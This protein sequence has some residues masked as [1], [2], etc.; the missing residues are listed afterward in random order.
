MAYPPVGQAGAGYPGGAAP[1]ASPSRTKWVLGVVIGVLAGALVAGTLG[2][3]I[4]A[5]GA[6]EKPNDPTS[7]PGP[8]TSLR[9]YEARQLALNKEKFSGDLAVLAEP[10]L[11][12]VGACAAN[13][14]PNGPKLPADEKVHVFCRYGNVS[15]HFAEYNSAANRDNARAYRHRLNLDG[16]DLVPGMGQP[17]RK[18]GGSTNAQG[19]YVEY[20]FRGSDGRALCGIWWDRDDSTSAAFYLETLC[21]ETLAGTW[22][23]LR[24]LWQ[25]YS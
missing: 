15:V 14:D 13:T 2:Y 18:H 4:G 16:F 6:D 21:Q 23:P 12:W 11:P 1:A 7:R 8:E 19:N 17:A 3:V 5:A 25:R 22:E 10:W 9:P 24:D 20:A